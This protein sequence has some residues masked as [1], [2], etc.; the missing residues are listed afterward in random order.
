M[1]L[2]GKVPRLVKNS[3]IGIFADTMN[4]VDVRL[5]M[6]VLYIELYLVIIIGFD[7]ISRLQQC[8]IVF[9]ENF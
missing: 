1:F 4:V 5:C 6:K 2:V 7:I 3:N 8:Q 9:I